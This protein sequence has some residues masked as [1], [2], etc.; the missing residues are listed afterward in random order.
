M[1]IFEEN[2]KFG[3]AFVDTTTHE[4]YLGDFEDDEYRSNLRTLVTR[5]KPIEIIFMKGCLS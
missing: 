2:F 5:I 4:F 3:V 1:A